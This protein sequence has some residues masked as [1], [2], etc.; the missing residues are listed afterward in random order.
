MLLLDRSFLLAA[1]MPFWLLDL[2]HAQVDLKHVET[3][4]PDSQESLLKG[5]VKVRGSI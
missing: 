5:H 3:N 2:P 1:L 4:V